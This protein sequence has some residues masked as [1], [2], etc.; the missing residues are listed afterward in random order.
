MAA[1]HIQAYTVH[2]K[3]YILSQENAYMTWSFDDKTHGIRLK[4]GFPP[5]INLPLTLIED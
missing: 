2:N 5:Q 1:T 3:V 4:A